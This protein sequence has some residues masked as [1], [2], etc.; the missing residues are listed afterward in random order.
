MD[1]TELTAVEREASE[2]EDDDVGQVGAAGL[3]LRRRFRRVLRAH[4]DGEVQKEGEAEDEEEKQEEMA[5]GDEDAMVFM[6]APTGSTRSSSSSSS[7]SRNGDADFYDQEDVALLARIKEELEEGNMVAKVQIVGAGPGQKLPGP[8]NSDESFV[9]AFRDGHVFLF[10]PPRWRSPMTSEQ[11]CMRLWNHLTAAL[12]SPT[13]KTAITNARATQRDP[14]VACKFSARVRPNETRTMQ[15]IHV[16]SENHQET[17]EAAAGA[18][19]AFVKCTAAGLE[20]GYRIVDLVV[21]PQPT[22]VRLG[23]RPLSVEQWRKVQPKTPAIEQSAAGK[24]G[25]KRGRDEVE[26]PEQEQPNEKYIR[27]AL[28]SAVE[29]PESPMHGAFHDG[30]MGKLIMQLKGLLALS[31]SDRAEHQGPSVQVGLELASKLCTLWRRYRSGV[32]DLSAP[33]TRSLRNFANALHRYVDEMRTSRPTA[34]NNAWG[35]HFGTPKFYIDAASPNTIC[36]AGAGT[37]LEQNVPVPAPATP[38][39]RPQRLQHMTTPPTDRA[40]QPLQQP[41][42][43]PLQQL[44]ELQAQALATWLTQGARHLLV[45]DLPYLSDDDQDLPSWRKAIEVLAEGGMASVLT[46]L[47]LWKN[48]NENRALIHEAIKNK[49]NVLYANLVVEAIDGAVQLVYDRQDQRR[50]ELTRGASS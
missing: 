49:T 20:A 4:R 28:I 30:H 33:C 45:A 15:H 41:Q 29:H 50:W 1:L 38:P 17:L 48:K 2:N 3:R 22:N 16:L 5:T 18:K 23:D 14:Q 46:I 26:P 21:E 27:D 31:A 10:Y 47:V 32:Q 25:K 42:P 13:M 8:G 40:R 39:P 11:R 35:Q 7:S 44:S 19:A 24:R 37:R 36:S 9:A 34:F 6:P 43:Q 12:H